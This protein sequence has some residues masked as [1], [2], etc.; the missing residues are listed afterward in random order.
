MPGVLGRIARVATAAIAVALMS[1][2]IAFSAV[3]G[4]AVGSIGSNVQVGLATSSLLG[5]GTIPFYI[6]LKQGDAC[7]YGVSNCGTYADTRDYGHGTS[8]DWG[9]PMNMILMF[10]PV[11]PNVEGTLRI[12][13]NDLDLVGGSDPYKFFETLEVFNSSGTSLT[14]PI[15]SLGGLVTGN[16]DNQYLS[17]LLTASDV[18]GN[19]L[20]VRLGFRTQYKDDEK[21]TNT[22]EYLQAKFT[23]VPVPAAGLLLIGAICTFGILRRWHVPVGFDR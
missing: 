8:D 4:V 19:P 5:P 22:L 14:G 11:T 16:A 1:S 3:V 9:R 7:T 20:Y 2:N 18:A 21:V 12:R 6:P 10:A 15:T 17:M 23:Q 13:F